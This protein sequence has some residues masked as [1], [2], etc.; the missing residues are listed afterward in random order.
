MPIGLIS[1]DLLVDLVWIN[2]GYLFGSGFVGWLWSACWVGFGL[3]V[4]CGF[5]CGGDVSWMC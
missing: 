3:D 4:A 2:C 5:R 1:F